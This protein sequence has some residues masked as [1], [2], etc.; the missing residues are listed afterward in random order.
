MFEEAANISPEEIK[1]YRN[2]VS[3]LQLEFRS[4]NYSTTGISGGSE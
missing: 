4:N 2:F 3:C 1:A